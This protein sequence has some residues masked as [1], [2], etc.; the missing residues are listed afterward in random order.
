M[1]LTNYGETKVLS[2]L[3]SSGTSYLAL[4]TA[5]AGEGG[6]GTEVSGGAYARQAIAFTNP[7][8][9]ASGVSSMSNS[10]QIEFPTATAAWGTVTGWAIFDAASG[11]NMLWY[12]T[13]GT[14]KAI[15][16]SDTILLH[17]GDLVLKAE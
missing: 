15:T 14:A 16:A 6:G 17:A 9:N 1:G 8:T 10:A 7:S 2:L 13:L 5:N 11:G 12:G 4:M 3:K